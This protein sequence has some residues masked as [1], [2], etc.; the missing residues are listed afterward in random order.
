MLILDP[1]TRAE[2]VQKKDRH[3]QE[4]KAAFHVREADATLPSL[5]RPASPRHQCCAPCHARAIA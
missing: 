4:T 5:L 3:M 2:L 1:D